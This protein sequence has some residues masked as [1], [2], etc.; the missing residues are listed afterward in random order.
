M[1]STKALAS[2][3]PGLLGSQL[4]PQESAEITDQLLSYSPGAQHLFLSFCIPQKLLPSS[5]IN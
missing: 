4:I 2:S 3:P 1:I 5:R